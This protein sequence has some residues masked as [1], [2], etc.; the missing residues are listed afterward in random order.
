M[1]M[2]GQ[3]VSVTTVTPGILIFTYLVTVDSRKFAIFLVQSTRWYRNAPVISSHRR[4][5]VVQA[6]R[7]T[8]FCLYLS[9]LLLCKF[10]TSPSTLA[11]IPFLSY[12]M[13]SYVRV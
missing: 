11:L 9:P 7:I 1:G 2:H 5:N 10:C 3:Q 8:F 6:Y 13:C 12:G 4:G